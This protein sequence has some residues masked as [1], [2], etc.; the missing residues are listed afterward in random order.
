ML[1]AQGRVCDRNDDVWRNAAIAKLHAQLDKRLNSTKRNENQRGFTETVALDNVL[2]GA[3]R[4]RP[5]ESISCTAVKRL[6]VT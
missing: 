5:V 6:P 3:W 4:I 1:T 2:D